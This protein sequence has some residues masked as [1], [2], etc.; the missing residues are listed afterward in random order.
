VSVEI[1]RALGR[2]E[3]KLD[4]LIPATEVTNARVSAVSAR[5]SKLEKWQSKVLGGAVVAGFLLGLIMRA[6]HI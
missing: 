6:L 2:I 3:G 5:V 1:E 4:L